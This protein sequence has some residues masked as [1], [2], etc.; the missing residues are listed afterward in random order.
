L[1]NFRFLIN[2]Q[3]NAQTI[4]EDL[5]VQLDVNRLYDVNIVAVNSRNEVIV[6]VPEANGTLEEVVESFM[7]S[8]QKGIIL[9]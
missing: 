7:D 9:E 4:A 8:Y 6:Q 5:K 1:K 3:F 2:D